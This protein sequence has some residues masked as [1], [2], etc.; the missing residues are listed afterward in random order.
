[1]LK[2]LINS[3]FC[4][5]VLGLLVG[6]VNADLI[7]HWALDEESGAVAYDSSPSAWDGIVSAGAEGNWVPDGGKLDGTFDFTGQDYII[8]PGFEPTDGIITVGV[9]AYARSR[10]GWSNLVTNWAGETGQLHFGQNPSGLL[11]LHYTQSSG[12]SVNTGD[13]EAFP[14]E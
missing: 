4:V 2:R 7:G 5:A 11:T 13:S 9:W 6:S 10:P 3:V 1:M 12:A 14:L 8:V